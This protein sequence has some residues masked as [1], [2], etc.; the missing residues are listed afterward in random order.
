MVKESHQLVGPLGPPPRHVRLRRG[1]RN[2]RR[3]YRT[4]LTRPADSGEA[5]LALSY[6]GAVKRDG[7]AEKA[8]RSLCRVILS[9]NEFIFVF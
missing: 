5:D 2:L 7:D 9:S 3:A 4:L 6:L 1:V 8:W